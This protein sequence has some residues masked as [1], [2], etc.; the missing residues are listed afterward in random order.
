MALAVLSADP[1]V[2]SASD[3]PSRLHLH[4]VEE[5]TERLTP[6][7]SGGFPPVW[8][9][10]AIRRS[11]P[12][13]WAEYCKLTFKTAYGIQKAFPGIDSKTAR[14]WIKGDHGPSGGFVAAVMRHDETAREMLGRDA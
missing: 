13:Q 11:F 5:V 6:A 1:A 12:Q 10:D 8:N 14:A 9:T 4:V 2:G 7:S 3:V